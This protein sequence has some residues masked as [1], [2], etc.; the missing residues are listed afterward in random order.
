LKL[1]AALKPADVQRSIA[2]AT[3][4]ATSTAISPSIQ[5]D[6]PIS[7]PQTNLQLKSPRKIL[8]IK[9]MPHTTTLPYGDE[10]WRKLLD[11][12][13]ELF[14]KG[15][16]KKCSDRCVAALEQVRGPVRKDLVCCLSPSSCYCLR[17][18]CVSSVLA[19]DLI[20]LCTRI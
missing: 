18:E 16:Y 12:V 11:E 4:T 14:Q 20:L 17:P 5:H 9:A 15:L 3:A 13:K 19:L 10:Q 7:V 1:A 2:I 8:R 6:L